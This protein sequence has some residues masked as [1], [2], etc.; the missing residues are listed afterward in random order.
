MPSLSMSETLVSIVDMAAKDTWACVT[1]GLMLAPLNA[2]APQSAD[3]TRT[4]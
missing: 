2:T 3:A 1:P 4:G